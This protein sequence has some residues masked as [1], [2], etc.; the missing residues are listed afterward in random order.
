M[1]VALRC[2]LDCFEKWR[3][4]LSQGESTI[5]ILQRRGNQKRLF[6]PA[7]R[8][9]TPSPGCAQRPPGKGG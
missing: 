2:D 6:N 1:D 5:A 9:P 8:S 3:K 4:P 7:V